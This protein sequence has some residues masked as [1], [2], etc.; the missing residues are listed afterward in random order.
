MVGMSTVPEVIV[1]IQCGIRVFAM[2]LVTNN[3]I[4]HRPVPFDAAM[5]TAS[6]ENVQSE[7]A[8]THEEVLAAGRAAEVLIEVRR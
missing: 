1:A 7:S 6:P 2:S 4:M 8:A 3:V 5:R